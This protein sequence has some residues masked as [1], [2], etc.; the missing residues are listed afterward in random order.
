[1][2]HHL[3]LITV[4]ICAILIVAGLLLSAHP[5][6]GS[7][8]A[9]YRNPKLPTE[10][11]VD[12]LLHRMSLEEKADMLSGAGWMETR[13]NPRHGIPSIKMADGPMGVRSWAGSSAVTNAPGSRL[14]Q[15][16]ATAFPVATAMAATWNPETCRTRGTGNRPGDKGTRPRHDSRTDG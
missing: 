5:Q 4:P 13:A 12:D 11:R 15:V 1:M 10:Q 9:P 2:N 14:P 3:L 16:S 7:D 6:S 8:A